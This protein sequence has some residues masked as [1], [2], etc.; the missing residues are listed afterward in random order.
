M[1]YKELKITTLEIAGLK[2]S[3]KAMRLPKKNSISDSYNCGGNFVF[4]DKDKHLAN[5]LISIGTEHCKFSRGIDVWVQ[6]EMQIGFMIEFVTYRIGIDDLSTSSS[7][8]NELKKL[9]GIELAE[10]K[11]VDLPNKVYTRIF[12]VSYQ[13]LK[14]MYSQRRNHRH[15]DWQIFCDWIEKLP[16]FDILIKNKI[17]EINK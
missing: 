13:C 6:I 15:P 10:Q 2:P 12:K 8:H 14:N 5:N 11:Q 7:M 3:L 4:G 17:K 9:K 16:N 1:N